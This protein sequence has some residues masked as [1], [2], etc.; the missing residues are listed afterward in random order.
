M[1]FKVQPAYRFDFA[2]VG[3][4][5]VA[6]L[7]HGRHDPIL[8][9]SQRLWTEPFF[10]TFADFVCVL[11]RFKTISLPELIKTLNRKVR[12]GTATKVAMNSARVLESGTP[13]G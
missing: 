10:L 7:N 4:S 8:A 9:D 3:L 11:C 2:I 1:D 6:T 13:A 5:Q 12:E